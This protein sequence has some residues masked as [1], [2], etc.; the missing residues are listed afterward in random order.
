[1]SP[2]QTLAEALKDRAQLLSFVLSQVKKKKIAKYKKIIK[3]YAIFFP[4]Y[5]RLR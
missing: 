4:K 1:M 5:Y 3:I 2:P